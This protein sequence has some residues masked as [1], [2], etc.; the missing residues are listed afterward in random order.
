MILNDFE[1]SPPDLA[2]IDK[3]NNRIVAS[4]EYFE[5]HKLTK[6]DLDMEFE[7][8]IQN[9]LVYQSITMIFAKGGAGKS[10]FLLA[11][12]LYLLHHEKITYCIYMDMDNST[13]ALKDRNLDEIVTQYPNLHYIHRSKTDKPAKE[14][15]EML[16]EDAHNNERG[17]EKVLI[18][19]DSIR[20]FLSGKDMNTDKDVAPLMEQLK[21]I[22]D[23]GATIIFLHH[24][25]KEHGNS[26]YKGSTS[27]IDSIDVAYGLEKT[28]LTDRLVSFSLTIEK[29]R[30]PVENTGF[31]LD[32]ES[33]ELRLGNYILASMTED[34][35]KFVTDIK[36]VLT[37]HTDGIKQSD[38]L[39]AIG[40]SSDDKTAR[41]RLK[42]FDGTLWFSKKIREKNNA[43]MYYPSQDEVPK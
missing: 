39:A 22:R 14:L 32:L 17:F 25:K 41:N 7:Y 28:T 9:F 19:L 15:I 16:A 24:T 3:K 27:F 29:D 6:N 4:L 38:L 23:A 18:I 11:L 5:K 35:T 31:E 33:F 30:I 37:V 20:D 40:T 26:Q 43:T 21:I 13:M 42:R 12:V 10:L 8:L 36:S 34:E 2:E 1:I